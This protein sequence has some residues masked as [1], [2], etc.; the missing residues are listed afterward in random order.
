MIRSILNR[1]VYK[2]IEN[3]NLIVEIIGRVF[4]I[5]LGRKNEY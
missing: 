2:L 1:K 4:T 3:M 5:A